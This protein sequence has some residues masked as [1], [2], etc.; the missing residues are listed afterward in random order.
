LGKLDH[1]CGLLTW[2]IGAGFYND[3]ERA[4]L[5]WSLKTCFSNKRDRM[6]YTDTSIKRSIP[7]KVSLQH[8]DGKLVV[9]AQTQTN[10]SDYII[11]NKT[12]Q[13][14]FKEIE[15]IAN[16]QD[17]TQNETILSYTLRAKIET[18]I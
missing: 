11:L 1:S 10:N 7:R 14:T 17:T 5:G 4:T 16:R 9:Q 2:G 8:R 3:L 6:K 15:E 18:L 13:M 12:A